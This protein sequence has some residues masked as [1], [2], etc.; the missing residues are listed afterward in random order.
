MKKIILVSLLFLLAEKN[1]YCQDP[2]FSQFYFSPLNLNPAMS[3]TGLNKSRV[4]FN[5]RLQWNRLW[6]NPFTYASASYDH[7]FR[8]NANRTYM[9]TAPF[10]YMSNFRFNAGGVANY[11]SEGFIRTTSVAG[12]LGATI[13]GDEDDESPIYL[14][15]AIKLGI[16][17]RSLNKNRLFFYDQ[18]NQNGYTGYESEVDIFKYNNFS[19]TTS[20]YSIGA[21]AT[22]KN[23]M[24]GFSVEQIK[25]KSFA[26]SGGETYAKQRITLYASGYFS[27]KNES[28]L[29][30]PTI[31]LQQQGDNH[32]RFTAGFLAD[33]LDYGLEVSLWYRSNQSILNKQNLSPGGAFSFGLVFN[34]NKT[35][36]YLTND[37]EKRFRMGVIYDK[38]MG[39]LPNGATAGSEE[40]GM[41]SEYG[42]T[43]TCPNK[44]GEAR[45][46]FPWM[47]L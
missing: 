20:F 1:G 36:N 7:S 45:K 19:F 37:V 21:L 34:I 22:I 13:G 43:N 15:G 6:R 39:S 47:F 46:K 3:G 40:F 9:G 4:C 16:L 41:V 31:I 17:N 10:N 8:S 27:S 30:R 25:D 44:Y 26:E 23:F 35:K 38:D 14:S 2:V 28:L 29:F 24:G 11:S 32:S 18:F 5:S 33:M 12:V 42:E